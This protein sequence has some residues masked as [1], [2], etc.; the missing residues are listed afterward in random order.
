VRIF[1]ADTS[2]VDCVPDNEALYGTVGSGATA[3]NPSNDR[4]TFHVS[5]SVACADWQNPPVAK[6]TVVVTADGL[7]GSTTLQQFSF[8][9]D[10]DATGAGGAYTYTQSFATNPNWLTNTTPDDGNNASV[11]TPF[12]NDHRCAVRR[13]EALRGIGNSSFGTAG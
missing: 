5:P 2:V 10:L 12:T 8:S 4:F 9:V 3:T 1:S 6:F 13:G 7:D 11:M